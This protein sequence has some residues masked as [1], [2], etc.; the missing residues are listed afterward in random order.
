MSLGPV[1]INKVR[2]KP[3]N[4]LSDQNGQDSPTRFRTQDCAQLEFE[5]HR[6]DHSATTRSI[7]VS[8]YHT[9]CLFLNHFGPADLGFIISYLPKVIL[10]K[11]ILIK[12]FM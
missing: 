2:R 7:T 8:V 6:L 12:A 11:N 4:K 1:L 10:F 9:K 5:V 3:T